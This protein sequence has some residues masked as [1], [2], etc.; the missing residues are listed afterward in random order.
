MRV[1]V[2]AYLEPPKTLRELQD[3]ASD[4][5]PGFDIHHIV[6][7]TPARQDGLPEWRIDAPEN[8]VAVPTY[9]HWE[10]TSWYQTRND[11]FGNLSPREYLRGQPWEVR[12]AVGLRALKIHGVLKP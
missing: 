1:I 6:E 9:R 4:P 7:Q 12:R 2:R 5:R 3:A 11:E 10:V 8:R